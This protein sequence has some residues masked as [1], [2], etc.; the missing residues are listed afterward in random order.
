MLTH[1]GHQIKDRLKVTHLVDKIEDQ[2]QCWI[3]N[4]KLGEI[5]KPTVSDKEVI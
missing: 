5:K 4:F 2:H 3:E 1:L